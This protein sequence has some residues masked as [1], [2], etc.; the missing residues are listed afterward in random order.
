MEDDGLSVEN[1]E[2]DIN[3]IAYKKFRQ[4]NGGLYDEVV[5]RFYAIE[6]PIDKFFERIPDEF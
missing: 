1:M 6:E 4:V 2:E 3:L 5:K